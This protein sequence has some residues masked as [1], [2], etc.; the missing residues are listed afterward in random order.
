MRFVIY[1]ILILSTFNAASQTGGL[2]TYQ[3]LS[4]PNSSRVASLGGNVLASSDSDINL[5]YHNP[6]ILD[7][8]M[9]KNFVLNYINYFSDINFGYVAYAHHH[10]KLGTFAA[11]IHYI[12]YGDFLRMDEMENYY[13]DFTG[14]EQ[15]FNLSWAKPLDSLFRIGGS[16][17]IIYSSLET[18]YSSGLALDFGAHYNNKERLFAAGIVVK[19]LGS[20]LKPF[21]KGNFEPLPF[22]IQIGMSKRLKHAPFR[23]YI[24]GQN[25]I[26]WNMVFTAE[27]MN[28]TDP[29]TGEI[30]KENKV[31][32]FADNF[33]RHFITGAE[34]ILSENFFI[35]FGYNY[36]RRQELKINTRAFTVGFS[37][38]FG[39]R[40]NRFH[41]SYGRATYHL[42][43]PSNHFSIS[44]NISEF[45]GKN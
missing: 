38:G 20:Q 8:E 26:N 10:E 32:K 24:S 35:R 2:S 13:G 23:F 1:I 9:D 42:A 28:L 19:N 18:Y 31:E 41:F 39:L 36:Q 7:N 29:I 44:T 6:A 43:G 21:V 12:N 14:Y 17:K 4:L 5:V 37:W 30:V 11:G 16:L 40:V 3:F 45:Y 25:L 34:L 15:S 22:D 27:D 33:M